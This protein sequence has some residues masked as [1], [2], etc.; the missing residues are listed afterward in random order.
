MHNGPLLPHLWARL[1]SRW[2]A[3]FL[4]V[5]LL[6]FFFIPAW[7]HTSGR[8]S[9]YSQDFAHFPLFAALAAILLYLWPRRH[10]AL[11]K[12]GVVAGLALLVAL[13]VEIIQPLAGRTAALSDWLIGA[14]GSFSAVAIYM[15][16]KT[17]SLRARRWLIM[18]AALLLVA[19]STPIAIMLLD[20]W[21]A[22]RAFPLIDSFE[23]FAESS[24]WRTDG[25]VLEQ[26]EE[27]A[28]HGR[29][30]LRLSVP[31]QPD[32]Y[33]GAYLSDGGMDWRGY[34]Q[35]TLDAF[36]EGESARSLIIQVEDA[37]RSSRQD[38][39]QVVVELK[40]GANRVA[41]DVPSFAITPLG[42]KLDM[43]HIAGVGLFLEG[44]RTGDAIF[45]DHL[46]LSGR[47]PPAEK[48]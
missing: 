29:Y 12:A 3:V 34:R 44:A 48:P 6:S 1:K 30:A 11:I 41:L 16:L 23:R 43:A 21:S 33:P 42:R 25:C 7:G 36:L 35:L 27:H 31:Q 40:P 39:A 13:L 46:T 22:H 14:A 20:R 5:T 8:F 9:S 37:S 18:A 4:V 10:T 28:T 38:R 26:V 32:R 24:R 2:P 45:L 47:L 19:A 15:G 17:A